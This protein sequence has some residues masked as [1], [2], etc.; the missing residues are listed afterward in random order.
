ALIARKYVVLEQRR[1]VPQDVGF[2]V[3]DFLKEHFPGIV[4]LSF[5]AHMEEDLDRIAGG[6]AQWVPV[7][8]EFFE[9]FIKLVEEK[10]RAIEKKD[11][12]EEATDKVCPYGH[13]MVI[14][15][16]RVGDLLFR[17]KYP[18]HEYRESLGEQPKPEIVDG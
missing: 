18:E 2:V 11:I 5:T 10:D 16:G 4:D 13:P 17:S 3:T 7:V 9:P 14:M 15:L 6:V 12:V 1:L 8:R